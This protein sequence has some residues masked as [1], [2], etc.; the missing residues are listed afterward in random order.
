MAATT[1]WNSLNYTGELFLIGAQ[2]RN[3][4]FLSM[5]GGID[6]ANAKT[7]GD[8]RFP[9][10]QPYTLASA[11]QPAI[12]ET[13]SLTAPTAVT[14]ARGQD[15]NVT[16]IFQEQVSVSYVAESSGARLGAAGLAQIGDNPVNSEFDFQLQSALLKVHNDANYTFLNGAYQLGTSAAVANKTRGIITATST[17]AVAAGSVDL[18]KD[19]LEEMFRTGAANGAQFMQPVIF[20]SALDVQR[21]SNIYGFAEMSRTVGGVNV[22]TI[23]SPLAGEVSVVWDVDVPAGTILCADM[24]VCYPVFTPVPEKGL[25]FY[26]ELSKTG[27]GT[28]GQLFGMMGIDYGPEEHHMKVTGLTTS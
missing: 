14:V 20:A 24:A 7:Y 10:A 1:S 2:L 16:S 11:S 9:V 15:F 23:I 4:K 3:K 17:N 25:L 6:G 27:A 26:E 18:S 5:I 19:I 28:S 22:S 21:I 8:T 13:A 12:T